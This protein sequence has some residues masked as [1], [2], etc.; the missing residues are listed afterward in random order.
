MLSK[1]GACSLR[2]KVPDNTAAAIGLG[3]GRPQA[4]PV[5]PLRLPLCPPLSRW[6]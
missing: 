4:P 5:L 3:V 2:I 6:Q 1:Q